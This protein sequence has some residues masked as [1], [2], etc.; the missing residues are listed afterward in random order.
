MNFAVRAQCD[1]VA[2]SAVAPRGGVKYPRLVLATSILASSL[3]FIDGSVVN[4]GLSVI[5]DALHADASALQWVV[6]AYLLPL[7]ALLLLGGAV[8]DRLGSGRVLSASIAAFGVSS[9]LCAVA[10]NLLWLLVG[11]ALQGTAAAFVLPNSL[12]VLGEAFSGEARG[13]AIGFWAA[14][15]AG[16]SAVGPILGGTFID[17]LGWR[18]IFLI[19]I[20]IALAGTWLAVRFVHDA[21]NTGA[22]RPLDT[23]GGVLATAGLGAFTYALTIGTGRDGWTLPAL[24]A[25][26][27]GIALLI[28]FVRTEKIRGDRA[29]IPLALLGS[30]AFVAITLLTL[31]LYAAFGGLLVLLPYMLITASHYSNM[32]AGA[33]L[34]PI[35]IVTATLSPMAGSLAGRIGSRRVLALGSL[36]VAA[37]FVLLLRVEPQ[38]LYWTSVFPGLLVL[39]LGMSAV[40]APLTTA[41]LAT[42]G[43][44]DTGSASG[45][46]SAV[47]RLG[48][49]IATALLGSVLA[50]SGAGFVA[51]FHNAAIAGA[52]ISVAAGASAL[53]MPKQAAK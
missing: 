36:L 20:P 12:A 30:R 19:N 7:S 25:L 39:S 11:R 17:H 45:F 3:A 28:A 26:A 29:M 42:A 47:A 2:F 33:S 48:G 32:A 10:P 37:G 5:R 13:R 16:I 24:V 53:V 50:A 43:P 21:R 8:G 6:N 40:A 38:G 18:T 31:F 4:V 51:D 35:P 49:L 44:D 46:N 23:L 15:G 41:V 34:L 22:R 27:A 14:V 1:A 52:I 9:V